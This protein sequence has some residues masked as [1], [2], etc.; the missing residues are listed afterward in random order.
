MI[1]SQQSQSQR[2]AH[3]H[4]RDAD[5]GTA[6]SGQVEEVIDLQ[7][8]TLIRA[9]YDDGSTMTLD[10]REISKPR[11]VSGPAVPILKTPKQLLSVLDLRLPFLA[12]ML[13]ILIG[14]VIALT[15]LNLNWQLEALTI[16]FTLL[17]A[18]ALWMLRIL[19]RR[20]IIR[21]QGQNN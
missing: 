13:A 8:Q 14:A 7:N 20:Q 18:Y 6:K 4:L 1:N 11:W 16:S 10:Q 9:Q 2:I 21:S 17:S 5:L 3:R 15:V 12:L 19:S